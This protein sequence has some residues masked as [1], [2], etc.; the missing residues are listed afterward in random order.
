MGYGVLLN[1]EC[2]LAAPQPKLL[3]GTS[4]QFWPCP[5]NPCRVDRW[6]LHSTWT[7]ST[8]KTVYLL[9]HAQ[10]AHN[11]TMTDALE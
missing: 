1:D 8:T 4:R 3:G 2:N 9:R 5:D 6:H 7:M 11:K 10:A